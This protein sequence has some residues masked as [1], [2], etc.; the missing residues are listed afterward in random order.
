MDTNTAVLVAIIELVGIVGSA[1]I[2]ARVTRNAFM[3]ELDKK[4]AV[5]DE[6]LINM[7]N[8]IREHNHYAKLFAETMPV[9]QEKMK[10]CENRIKDLERNE[11]ENK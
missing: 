9:V 2:T 4:V 3:H 11:H 8:D 5:I 10:V 6:K 1:Y 7:G